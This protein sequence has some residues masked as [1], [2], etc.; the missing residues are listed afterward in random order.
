DQDELSKDLNDLLA[1]TAHILTSAGLDP[2]W[3]IESAR[4]TLSA[5][6]PSERVVKQIQN[7]FYGLSVPRK[8]AIAVSTLVLTTC[9][10]LGLG[11]SQFANNRANTMLADLAGRMGKEQI[12]EVAT[13]RNSGFLL[14]AELHES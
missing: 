5:S 9:F 11:W 12:R 14:L 13:G 8:A 1:S 7:A 4:T 3:A 10:A 6:V 2:C